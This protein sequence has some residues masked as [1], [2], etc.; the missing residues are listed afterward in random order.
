M[1]GS[2][3]LTVA[4][5]MPGSLAEISGL[6]SGDVLVAVNDKATDDY[7]MS[8]LGAIFRSNDAL[9]I[10]VDRDGEAVTVEIE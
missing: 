2:G 8:E 6:Q 9:M 10:E 7:E 3:S 5:V 4:A 1:Q